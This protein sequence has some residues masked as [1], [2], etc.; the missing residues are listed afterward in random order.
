[1]NNTKWET[2]FHEQNL[3]LRAS[4]PYLIDLFSDI[5]GRG[6]HEWPCLSQSQIPMQC[7]R[8]LLLLG[9]TAKLAPTK[10]TSRGRTASSFPCLLSLSLL[11][12][13]HTLPQKHGRLPSR[14]MS[15]L[16]LL[17]NLWG[18]LFIVCCAATWGHPSSSSEQQACSQAG[19]SG[20][21]GPGRFGIHRVAEACRTLLIYPF[22]CLLYLARESPKGPAASS[23]ILSHC[24]R[25][26]RAQQVSG[27]TCLCYSLNSKF[28]ILFWDIQN[29]THL[30]TYT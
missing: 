30:S 24:V 18:W 27:L 7:F 25:L 28:P 17:L 19:W 9:L 2:L 6:L 21:S 3:T 16:L 23:L 13:V 5:S 15:A 11:S 29:L 1:M 22:W 8:C 14:S 4:C 20:S 10:I 26:P 12:L